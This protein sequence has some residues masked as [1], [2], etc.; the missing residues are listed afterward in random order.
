M[1]WEERKPLRLNR[2]WRDRHRGILKPS[3]PHLGVTLGSEYTPGMYGCI[4]VS[5][6]GRIDVCVYG[7]TDVCDYVCMYGCMDV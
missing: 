1:G 5:M 6:Y 3:W 2:C 4:D 7:C